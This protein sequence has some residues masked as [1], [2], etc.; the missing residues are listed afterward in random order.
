MRFLI[1]TWFLFA[2]SL[3]AFAVESFD[4]SSAEL[5]EKQGTEGELGVVA[6]K[7]LEEV[8]ALLGEDGEAF[9]TRKLAC[10]A[11]DIAIEVEGCDEIAQEG[12]AESIVREHAWP[13]SPEGQVDAGEMVLMPGQDGGYTP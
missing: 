5:I 1:P 8:F 3:P 2:V 12:D 10:Q 6:I 4:C 7:G 13:V 9:C 11:S